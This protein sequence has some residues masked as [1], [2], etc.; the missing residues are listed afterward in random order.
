MGC[1][2]SKSGA[3]V[4]IASTLTTTRALKPANKVQGFII[5]VKEGPSVNICEPP[6]KTTT[7]TTLTK[8]TTEPD[9]KYTSSES[10]PSTSTSKTTSAASS[11]SHG[12]ARSKDSGLGGDGESDHIIT[13]KSSP[14]LKHVAD[15]P[16]ELPE[17]DLAVEGKQMRTPGPMGH[18]KRRSAR[19]PPV[20]SRSKMARDEADS[21][22]LEAI[23]MK[24]VKFADILINELPTTD[25]IVKRPVSRGGVAFDI[26]MGDV[27]IEKGNAAAEGE[28]GKKA[29]PCVRN[30]AKQRRLT[31][32]VTHAE[33]EKKQRAAEQRRKACLVATY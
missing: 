30:Y 24:R 3:E 10:L 29:P 25:S 1:G 5:T 12:S 16:E 22:R 15:I 19:L 23:L 8:K 13:E 9:L 28:V 2:S 4:S 31:D 26:L 27:E 21:I 14:K 32:I 6:T 20:Y 17:A 7:V 33:L 18:L 11:H